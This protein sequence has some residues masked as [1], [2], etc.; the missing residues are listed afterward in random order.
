MLLYSYIAWQNKRKIGRSLYWKQVKNPIY[1]RLNSSL[2]WA[3]FAF[4]SLCSTRKDGRYF[5]PSAQKGTFGLHSQQSITWERHN[6]HKNSYIQAEFIFQPLAIPSSRMQSYITIWRTGEATRG[7]EWEPLKISQSR[8]W[9]L[10]PWPN[11]KSRDTKNT[12]QKN[13]STMDRLFAPTKFYRR[14]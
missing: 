13:N 10:I 11:P 7:C 14:T 8:A 3:N 9:G 2:I 12:P 6:H 4:V 1:T 5:S